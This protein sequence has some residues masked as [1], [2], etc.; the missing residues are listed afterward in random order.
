MGGWAYN[1]RTDTHV[2]GRIEERHRGR[3]ESASSRMLLA[4]RQKN[5][6]KTI[7]NHLKK[8]LKKHLKKQLKNT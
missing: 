3:Q 8:Q 7:K 1:G 2:D 6:K 5:N 4:G